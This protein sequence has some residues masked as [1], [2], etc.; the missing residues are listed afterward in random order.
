MPARHNSTTA[1]ATAADET[2]A[3]RA[4]SSS[5][6]GVEDSSDSISSANVSVD[7]TLEQR[8]ADRVGVAGAFLNFI[9][10]FMDDA[11]GLPLKIAVG[12]NY[13]HFL[14]D[15]EWIAVLLFGVLGY[16]L[17]RGAADRKTT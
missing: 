2:P 10:N 15:A 5:L 6:A 11:T 4:R 9:P 17:L 7:A 16:L 12:Y 3:S 14:W 8:H 13:L 1:D